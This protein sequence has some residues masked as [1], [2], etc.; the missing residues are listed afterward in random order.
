MYLIGGD[1][2]HKSGARRLLEDLAKDRERLV[3]DAEVFQE[4]LHRYSSINRRDSIQPAFEILL[5]LVDEILAVDLPAVARA[6][7]ILM[8][9]PRISSRDALHLSIME[10][11]EV[12]RILSCDSGFDGFPGITRLA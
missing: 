9:H 5:A 12:E 8:A 11:H 6:K 7:E 10:R 3:T 1:H 2:P 4:I